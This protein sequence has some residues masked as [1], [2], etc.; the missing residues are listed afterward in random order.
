MK[1]MILAAAALMMAAGAS[2]Q[3]PSFEWGVK[4]GLN[5][6]GVSNID[7]S[8]MKAS[9]Y[10]GAFA[11]FHVNDWLGIQPEVIYSR[12]GFAVDDNS[13]D[14]ARARLNYLNIPIM[15]KFYVLDNLSF[16]T[17]PQFGF[18]LN[19]REKVK[20]EGTTVK[21]DI[22]GAKNFDVSWG[23]GVSYRIFDPLDVTFR[24]NIGLTKIWDTQ[25]NTPKNGVIQIGVG[26]RF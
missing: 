8:N 24:Y 10:V 22:D 13:V 9:I 18:L 16:E 25:D 20:A 14:Y 4:A 12:Q 3:M 5:V 7:D 21:A 26:Y 19:A 1:K 15:G 23:V 17:G 2:A 11:E 6:S